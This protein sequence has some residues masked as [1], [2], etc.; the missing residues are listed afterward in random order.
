[1]KQVLLLAL[2]LPASMQ[3]AQSPRQHPVKSQARQFKL[4]VPSATWEPIF[5]KS[6]NERARVAN[7]STLRVALPKDDL[8]LRL[9]NGFGLTA[10]EGFVLRRRAGRW[11]AI[12]L[13]GIHPRLPR[14]KYEKHLS[15]PTSGWNECWRRLVELG[16]LTLPDVAEIDCSEMDPDGMSYVV[17][18]NYEFTYRTYMYDN[19]AYA[20]CEQA[21]SMINIGN[22]I[23]DEF[24]VPEMA[25][26]K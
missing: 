8:E 1:M 16:I 6:I 13:D 4:I 23:A 26:R 25:T 24:D 5:F 19:P 17:E 10:L 18:I 7:L 21:K 3:V 20:K 2:L 12:H 9:W 14:E 22:L 11:S 15:A